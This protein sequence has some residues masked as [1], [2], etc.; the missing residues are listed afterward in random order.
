MQVEQYADR[1]G[2]TAELVD[3]LHAVVEELEALH[4]GRKFP[5]DGH[6]VGSLGEAAG[7]ALFDVELVRLSN[8]GY[9]AIA[10]DG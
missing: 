9:D 3:Q 10:S 4:P 2:R 5:L 6:L 1:T 8:R 7:E